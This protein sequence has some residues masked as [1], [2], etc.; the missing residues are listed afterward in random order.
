MKFKAFTAAFF[1]AVSSY[2]SSA[3]TL[4]DGFTRGKPSDLLLAVY[5]NSEGGAGA[6]KTLLFNTNISYG[7]IVNGTAGAK[8]VDLSAD[9]N[10]Q[11]LNASGAKLV[12]NVV[13]GYSLSDDFSN[14]DKT[15]SS[16]RIFSDPASTQWGVLTTGKNAADFTG[17]LIGLGD[18]TKNRIYA[19]WFAA[20][21]KLAAAGATATS[22][23]N[24]VLV[25]KGD[26]QASFDLAWG[27]NFG[28]GGS[29]RTAKANIGNV[30][31]SLKLFWITN[32]DFA[33][34][35]VVEFGTISL[36]SNGKLTFTPTGGGGGGGN[37]PPIAKTGADQKV[38]KG[39]LVTLDGSQSSDPEGATLSFD[40]AQTSGPSV[41]LSNGKTA[42]S[43]FTPQADGVYEFK[44]TVSDGKD[45]ATAST[46][47]TVATVSELKVDAPASWKVKGKQ[48]IK[49]SGPTLDQKAKVD[50]HFAKDGVSFRKIG[51][52]TLKKG[53]FTW[54]PK[55]ADET[56]KGALRATAVVGTGANKKTVES[57]TLSIVVNK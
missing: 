30:G 48:T 25:P 45:S 38:S 8:S 6:G 51:S 27:G 54:T 57:N 34:G 42:K 5:D 36:A 47:V 23:P 12:Y 50:I 20:N 13:G 4:L 19:Y 44:L 24:S 17:D 2:D 10:F 9:P 28:G 41:S 1:L 35:A 29:A 53:A 40:W 21:V 52:S 14:Y 43:S 39:T 3:R 49:F 32:T 22:G 18:T 37:K 11:A 46:K 15:G 26:P 31:E 33:K 7:D 56:P 16:G 55:P